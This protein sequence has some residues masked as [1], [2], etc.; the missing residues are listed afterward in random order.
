MLF[1]YL[2]DI[3]G[4]FFILFGYLFGLIFGINWHYDGVILCMI[5][6]RKLFME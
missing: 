1:L 6:T 4:Y 3:I 2:F 5:V